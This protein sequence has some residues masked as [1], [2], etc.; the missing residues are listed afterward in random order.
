MGLMSGWMRGRSNGRGRIIEHEL[1]M[2]RTPP[3]KSIT[4]NTLRRLLGGLKP[5]GALVGTPMRSVD[6]DLE[7][8]WPSGNRQ[9]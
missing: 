4:P 3:G 9:T 8:R 6:R 5:N 1:D 7:D 2:L